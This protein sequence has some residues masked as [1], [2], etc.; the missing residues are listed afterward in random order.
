MSSLLVFN[1]VYKLEIQ[2]VMLVFSTPHVNKCPLTFSLAVMGKHPDL[3]V[4]HP[5]ST[6]F[7]TI[8]RN[9]EIS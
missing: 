6:I 5:T 3:M 1:K 8:G 2:S 4:A 7:P 9:F